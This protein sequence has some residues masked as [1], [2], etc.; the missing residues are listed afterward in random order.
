MLLSFTMTNCSFICRPVYSL[1]FECAGV[2]I[3]PV[4]HRVSCILVLSI[5]AVTR[6]SGGCRNVVQ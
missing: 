2:L 6:Y 3:Y 5:A 1:T 4:M